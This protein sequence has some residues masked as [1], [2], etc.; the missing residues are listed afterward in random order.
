MAIQRRPEHCQAWRCREIA[1]L[2]P[3]VGLW[4]GR[5]FC[6]SHGFLYWMNTQPEAAGHPAVWATAPAISRQPVGL[7]RLERTL[8]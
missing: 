7:G 3:C 1:V 4:R 6:H 8:R 2:C 5:Q